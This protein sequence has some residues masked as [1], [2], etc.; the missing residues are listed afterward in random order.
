MNINDIYYT[1]YLK[2]KNKYL[3]VKE[4]IGG[5]ILPC[6]KEVTKETQDYSVIDFIVKFDCSYNQI[7]KHIRNKLDQFNYCMLQDYNS[8]NKDQITIENL[9]KKGFTPEILKKFEFPLSE[10]IKS[11]GKSAYKLYQLGYSFKEMK[12]VGISLTD[13][14]SAGFTE[15]KELSTPKLMNDIREAGFFTPVEDKEYN[16]E[17]ILAAIKDESGNLDS[18]KLRAINDKRKRQIPLSLIEDLPLDILAWGGYSLTELMNLKFKSN[19]NDIDILK[20]FIRIL[21]IGTNSSFFSLLKERFSLDDLIKMGIT[22]EDILVIGYNPC[23]LKELGFLASSFI[24]IVKEKPLLINKLSCYTLKE[25]KDAGYNEKQILKLPYSLEEL[26]SN[27]YTLKHLLKIFEKVDDIPNNILELFP[28]DDILKDITFSNKDFGYWNVK[29]IIREKILALS[30]PELK[31]GFTV[32]T[33]INKFNFSI[34]EL[35]K[36]GFVIDEFKDFS[37]VVINLKRKGFNLDYFKCHKFSVEKLKEGGYTAKE[38]KEGG[39]TV[40]ELKSYYI[41]LVIKEAGY[42]IRE[43]SEADF[44]P[45]DIFQIGFDIREILE[46]FNDLDL[47]RYLILLR[48]AAGKKGDEEKVESIKQIF[49][50]KDDLMT[51]Y[52][53]R[54][55]NISLHLIINAIINGRSLS[56]YEMDGIIDNLKFVFTEEDFVRQHVPLDYYAK[57]FPHRDL[58]KLGISI[59]ALTQIVKSPNYGEEEDALQSMSSSYRDDPKLSVKAAILDGKKLEELERKF[60]ILLIKKTLS[61]YFNVPYMT[62]LHPYYKIFKKIV[63]EIFKKENSL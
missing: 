37:N 35:L 51:L 53:L 44:S 12:E 30:L 16:K 10:I 41:P 49:Q 45:I 7:N 60:N 39:Y 62:P 46:N 34:E 42:N 20:D 55:H 13:L 24:N 63:D 25:L 8:K 36:L 48:T 27:G 43:L 23:E 19:P 31:R 40:R 14:K 28:L 15:K 38:L 4:Q 1:K 33:L 3:N 32:E 22:I 2:Y 61:Y 21:K 6:P 50:I 11:T 29:S 9:K 59:N 52:C 54:K 47:D 18:M 57:K 5:I 26:I 58:I 56:E 17:E